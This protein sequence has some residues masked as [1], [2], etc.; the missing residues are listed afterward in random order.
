[1][2][3]ARTAGW[4]PTSRWTTNDTVT[5]LVADGSREGAR[6]RRPARP[7]ERQ[8]M[9]LGAR[10][11]R[12][13]HARGCLGVGARGPSCVS[14]SLP[15]VRRRMTPL[16]ALVAGQLV[17]L[18][19]TGLAT[20]LQFPVW[21]L[22]DEG[23]HFDY[24]TRIADDGRIPVL[25]RDLVSDDVQAITEDVYPFPPRTG[26]REAG[27]AGQSYE[28][29]QPPLYYVLAAPASLAVD[30]A[31]DR[32]TLLRALNLVLLFGTV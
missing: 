3:G 22:V 23:A 31:Q 27:L 30:D 20:V 26:Q 5:G 8:G 24:V 16:R 1:M 2:S 13:Q 11:P 32:V 12:R 17:L 9:G 4:A 10:D 14:G 19:G 25:D 7:V 18:L 28:G 6:R 29:V 21:A 15:R